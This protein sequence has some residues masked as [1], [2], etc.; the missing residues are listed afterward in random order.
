MCQKTGVAASLMRIGRDDTLRSGLFV[1]CTETA[2]IRTILL[3]GT[4]LIT[5]MLYR[6]VGSRGREQSWHYSY[7]RP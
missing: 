2:W 5:I 7:Y 1:V 4:V 3:G 6:K